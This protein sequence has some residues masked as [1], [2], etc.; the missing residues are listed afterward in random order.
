[1]GVDVVYVGQLHAGFLN[2]LFHGE[3]GSETLWVGC[4][5]VIGVGGEA[6]AGD[7]GV[8]FGST[9]FGMFVFFE[10]KRSGSF[11]EYET[12]AVFVIR[13]GSGGG[14]IVAEGE[15]FHGGEAAY[16]AGNDGCFA[17]TCDHDVDFA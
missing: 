9:G 16:A 8:D 14:V 7:F 5:D 6:A 11:A 1:M 4:S 2:G 3:H 15:G 17:A 12:V 10:D 13:T